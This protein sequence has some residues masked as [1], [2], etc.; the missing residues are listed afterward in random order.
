MRPGAGRSP[1]PPVTLT[2]ASRLPPGAH[3]HGQ[4]RGAVAAA[5]EVAGPLRDEA[6]RAAPDAPARRERAG[7]RGADRLVLP[8]V[9]AGREDAHGD[10]L[11]AARRREAPRDGDR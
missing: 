6:R 10:A 5:A 7:R 3:P 1:G 9:R 2:A 11:V 8:A 4:R